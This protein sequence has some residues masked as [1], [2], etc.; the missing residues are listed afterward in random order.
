MTQREHRC[1]CLEMIAYNF[2][3]P[4]NA[5]CS[6]HPWEPVIM[7]HVMSIA[8]Q[9]S[10]HVCFPLCRPPSPLL[11]LWWGLALIMR[12]I[13]CLALQHYPFCFLS[14]VKILHFSEGSSSSLLMK[15]PTLGS[16]CLWL[17]SG[18]TS[19]K[20]NH[21]FYSC[22]LLAVGFGRASSIPRVASRP[23]NC[24]PPCVPN[25]LAL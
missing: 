4:V 11:H 18:R 1:R 16:L 7:P 14:Q 23:H 20:Q 3:L 2:S 8:S 10:P 9:R 19:L 13:F 15:L 6:V 17:I 5:K 22:I 24:V 25:L 21:T 12:T